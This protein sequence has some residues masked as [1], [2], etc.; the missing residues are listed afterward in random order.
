MNSLTRSLATA[1]ALAVF[2][3]AAHA[4]IERTIEKSFAVKGTGTLKVDTQGGE[5]RISPSNDPVVK[6]T[7]KEKIR[8]DTDAEAD[9]LLKKLE[10][11]L[12]QNGNDVVAS[13]KY[14]RQPSGFHFGSWPPVN[15]DFVIT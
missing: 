7:V 11:T 2:T 15:V 5:I 3:V 10:L 9:E 14:E 1:A 8:A 6:I 13:A 4:K 12:E